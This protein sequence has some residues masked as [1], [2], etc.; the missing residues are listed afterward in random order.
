MVDTAR[1]ASSSQVTLTQARPTETSPVLA[2]NGA[3]ALIQLMVAQ[4]V[5][6]IFLNPGTDTAPL[7][8]A[9]V[10]LGED[11]QRVPRIIP[12]LYENV[13]LAGAH[14]FFA[15][16]RRPQV[17]VV[18]V[19]VGT[20]NLGGNVHNAQRGRG[21][22]VILA[23]RA[24]Y[25]LDDTPGSRS[26]AIHWQQEQLDQIGI[27]RN[28]VKWASELPRT[29]TLR[30]LVPRAFQIAAAEPA[31]PVYMMIAREVL[32]EPMEGVA[33]LPASRI[34]PPATPTGAPTEIE[35]LAAWLADADAPLA[36]PG[37][38]GHHPEAV[39]E[40]VE[41]ADLLGMA[42]GGPRGPVN[43]PSSNPLSVGA[44]SAE[45]LAAS[46]VILL[47]DVDV[48]WI[49]SAMQ[50]ASTAKIA[51]IDID[52][53]RQ[54]IPLWGFPV[55]LPIQADSAKTLPQLR[56][57]VERLAT[58]ERRRRWAA[59]RDRL[60]DERQRREAR[61]AQEAEAAR[62]Q[63]P[64][65]LRWLGAVLAETVPDDAIVVDE[66][67][68][69]GGIIHNYLRRDA[70]GSLLYASGTGLGWALGA[71]IGAK[72]AEPARDVIV[73][74]GDGSFVFGSPVAALWGA[75]QAQAPFLTIV[76][77]NGGY[78]A[79]KMPIHQLFPDGASMRLDKYPGVRWPTPPDY[80]KL[81]ES[82]HAY[83]ER[84]ED[85]AELGA[86]IERGLARVRAG[87]AALLDVILSPI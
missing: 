7:Q 71:A 67:V 82:C 47:L 48:P 81:A 31:G 2:R 59:R 29:D 37:L 6:Y 78:N 55:D 16:T 58:P 50:P 5:E 35:L 52:P 8:E 42:V 11:G 73:L 23:G 51:Q 32:R 10:A 69:S 75:Q 34:R 28:Y 18:H 40:L 19:D 22:V 12:C 17:V 1:G 86:A 56:E 84:V 27:V 62:D 87:Q 80:A 60:A 70:P 76:F 25:T 57:A 53:L 45:R 43:F 9:I 77:N 21:G 39:P 20:Q 49:P 44:L 14:G 24:P 83:G 4:G 66:M 54:T 30:D 85:P 61:L 38:T 26:G 36:V 33:P 64:I 13:A 68:T 65:S 72:L 15:I 79:S 41:L 63:R 46:D 3:E 74:C